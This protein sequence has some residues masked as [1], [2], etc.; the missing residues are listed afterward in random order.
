M[1]GK[2]LWDK[3]FVYCVWDDRLKG[4]YVFVADYVSDLMDYVEQDEV[5]CKRHLV[6]ESRVIDFPFAVYD[7]NPFSFET[8]DR[9]R[10][11]YFDPVYDFKKAYYKEGKKIQMWDWARE[12]WEDVESEPD[13][14]KK[15]E[16]YRVKP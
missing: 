8:V 12:V 15:P 16:F 7:D 9:K 13:W 14:G 5:S 2:K 3:K 4:N 11:C 1:S 10:Y 6:E